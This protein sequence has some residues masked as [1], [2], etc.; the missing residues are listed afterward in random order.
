M[1]QLYKWG[2]ILSWKDGINKSLSHKNLIY[3][4][5]ISVKKINKLVYIGYF[6]VLP[7]DASK[8]YDNKLFAHVHVHFDNKPS[9][10]NTSMLLFSKSFIYILK[11]QNSSELI[12][13]NRDEFSWIKDAT[14]DSDS[15]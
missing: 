10:V 9:I 8:N 3:D 15:D 14:S 13:D 1:R 5:M 12:L 11:N 6:T 4:K 2:T 7:I